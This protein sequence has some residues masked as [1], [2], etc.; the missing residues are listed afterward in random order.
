MAARH[1]VQA[2]VTWHLWQVRVVSLGGTQ[3][4]KWWGLEE[5]DGLVCM[6]IQLYTLLCRVLFVYSLPSFLQ[7]RLNHVTAMTGPF[8]GQPSYT[9]YVTLL[10]KMSGA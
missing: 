2:L 5:G 3:R 8:G 10:E 1:V 7:S 9:N 6:Y 4:Y